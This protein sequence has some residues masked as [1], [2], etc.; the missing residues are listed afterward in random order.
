MDRCQ[1]KRVSIVAPCHNEE[2]VL[3]D[4]LCEVEDL[5]LQR[6]DY[7]WE[8][9]CVDDGSTDESWR[10]I[11]EAVIEG[12]TVRGISLSRNFGHQAAVSAG[13]SESTGDCVGVIDA[14]LQDP[15]LVLGEFL[16]SWEAGS[17]VV[18]GVRKK[19]DDNKFK[20]L[21]AWV[22]YRSLRRLSALEIPVDAGDFCLMDR[23]VVEVMK[24]LPERNRYL[25]GMRVWCGF[26]HCSVEF[27]RR[28]RL[29]GEPAY[30]L[31]KSFKLALDGLFSFSAV[32][33]GLASHL[34]LWIS[35]LAF[36]GAVFTFFQRV[37]PSF[38]GS[39]GLAPEP[40]FATIVIS[41]LFLGGIQLICLGILGEY[42][43]RIYEEVKG[44]PNWIVAKRSKEDE[45]EK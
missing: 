3:P 33:L 43:G 1:K 26:E 9:I 16:E 40:G 15:P 37:F 6:S 8:L 30:T 36:L 4:F 38:F 19:R 29:G 23:K 27:E 34:G 13:L 28:A 24:C 31:R 10:I 18:Y 20:K 32:P 22:F 12:G 44:R 2:E 11:S 42:L 45:G 25:R 41:I 35:L 21:L 39:L 7:E 17:D 14:D 5:F